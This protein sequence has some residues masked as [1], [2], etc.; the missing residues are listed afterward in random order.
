MLFG[1]YGFITKPKII[2]ING[3]SKILYSNFF[4]NIFSKMKY[5]TINK[6]WNTKVLCNK[7]KIKEVS[8]KNKYFFL[9]RK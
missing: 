5:N 6:S 8:A 3:Y 4:E 1:K 9:C 7:T 2:P